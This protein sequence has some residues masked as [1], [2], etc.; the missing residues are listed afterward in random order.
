MSG[1][2]IWASETVT[3]WMWQCVLGL[4][5]SFSALSLPPLPV[6]VGCC[7]GELTPFLYL[8][9]FS[10]LLAVKDSTPLCVRAPSMLHSSPAGVHL[11]GLE[12]GESGP[13]LH[14]LLPSSWEWRSEQKSACRLWET[15]LWLLCLHNRVLTFTGTFSTRY[16]FDM[17]IIIASGDVK[18][19]SWNPHSWA[20][21]AERPGD[22]DTQSCVSLCFHNSTFT[23][24]LSKE[25]D[26][27][28]SHVAHLLL[29]LLE[30]IFGHSVK[31]SAHN[32]IEKW[33]T[34]IKTISVNL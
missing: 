32:I 27:N 12:P 10:T 8:C 19:Q 17:N 22:P 16:I 26:L 1:W 14:S 2:K 13:S 18:A 5:P 9:L 6:Q 28:C 31:I 34:C 25:T 4:D 11:C 23:K 33:L 24:Q 3:G 21:G 29:N 15:A 20:E 7:D 30:W